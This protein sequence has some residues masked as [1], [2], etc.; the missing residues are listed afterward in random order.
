MNNQDFR[1]KYRPQCFAEVIGNK[2]PIKILKNMVKTGDIRKGI[3]FHGPPGSGKTTLAHLLIKGLLCEKFSDDVCNK[4]KNCRSFKSNLCG[5]EAF[6]SCHDC[7]RITAK[8]VDEIID[9]LKNIPEAKLRPDLKVKLHIHI[10]DE[11]HRAKEPIQDKFL[12]PLERMPD[13]LLV[14]CRIDLKRGD[15]D[16]FLQ[17]VTVLKTAPPEV[18]DLVPWLQ[19]ICAAEGIIVKD[20]NALKELAIRGHRLPRECLGLLEKA[21]LLGDPL[22]TDLVRELAQDSQESKYTLVE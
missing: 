17:R 5:P 4:C 21:Y 11:F 8:K 7:S 12:I 10:F 14:F 19:R 1:Q 22:S 3:L 6:F 2:T 18:D 20:N 13:I 16:A 9:S 15:N